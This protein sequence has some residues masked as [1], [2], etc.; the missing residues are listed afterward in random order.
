[1]A[2]TFNAGYVRDMALVA[3]MATELAKQTGEFELLPAHVINHAHEFARAVE[4][5]LAANG[6]Q[7]QV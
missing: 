7:P 5:Y 3:I 6:A 4:L 2:I 1:M